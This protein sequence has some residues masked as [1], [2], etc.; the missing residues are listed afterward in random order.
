M[1]GSVKC[2]EQKWLFDDANP[3][4]AKFGSTDTEI[5]Q[6]RTEH[7]RWA[8]I[9]QEEEIYEETIASLDEIKFMSSDDT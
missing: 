3:F 4:W 9:D 7:P 6:L 2:A 5:E 8:T 1:I